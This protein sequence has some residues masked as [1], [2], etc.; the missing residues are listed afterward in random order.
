M[1]AGSNPLALRRLS[2]ML[3]VSMFASWTE[4]KAAVLAY[5]GFDYAVGSALEGSGSANTQ[6]TGAWDTLGGTTTIRSGSLVYMDS[7]GDTLA[8][9]GQSILNTGISGTNSQQGRNLVARRGTDG[10]ST[11]ISFVGQ[12]IGDKSPT[13]VRG[14]NLTLIDTTATN[15]ERLN[16]GENS[17]LAQ[18]VWMV[19]QPPGS[20]NDKFSTVPF[21]TLSLF[22]ARID[23][24]SGNDDYFFWM[25]PLLKTI[26]SDASA[27]GSSLGITDLSFDR[28]RTFA[29]N[30][31]GGNPYAE[32]LIDEIRIGETYSDVVAT[33]AIPIL[34]GDTDTD[35]IPGE[36][37]DDF[38]PIRANFRKPVTARNQ[39]D[40]VPNGVVDFDDFRQWK[41]AHLAGGGSMAGI[42]LFASV[43]E[44]AALS[45]V[46]LASLLI[47]L[48]NARRKPQS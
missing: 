14:A 17:N 24:K 33:S 42:D 6:W 7:Q 11:W 15:A 23:H 19:R 44:P 28:I 32:W 13:F 26:P 9:T 43:P 46:A 39:G 18:D 22:V 5:E 16:I 1:T 29:G 47:A 30:P 25:N 41:T 21:E 34:P 48:A 8:A 2:C 31:S 3:A 20:A 40:L 35:G 38:E 10:T 12:R 36:F 4:A 37:P 27:A 45:T